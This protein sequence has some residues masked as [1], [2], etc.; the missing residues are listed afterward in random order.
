MMIRIRQTAVAGSF[1][2]AEADELRVEVQRLLDSVHAHAGPAPRAL[3]VPHAGY[4]YSG[5]VAAAAYERL[6]PWRHNYRRVLLMGPC[7]RVAL[8]GMAVSGADYFQTPLGDVPLDRKSI[9]SLSHPDLAVADDAH[10]AEHSLEVQLPFLQ[11]VLDSFTLVPIVVGDAR[12]QA[13]SEV[14]DA[15]WEDPETLV[16]ISS[17]LSHYLDYQ[18]ARSRDRTTCY[19]I[20]ALE[21]S[22][23]GATDACGATPLQGLLIAAGRRGL[24]AVTL[25]LRNSGDT[26]GPQE[27][28]VGYG[29]WMFV[30]EASWNH[31]A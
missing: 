27:R 25:D 10:F 23:I 11:S 22:R 18:T 2:P 14:I 20:E 17:D 4:I 1:Y 24:R 30:E 28:V 16:V 6:R 19:A 7:H 26:A 13:V 9:A 12:P 21:G 31:A 3:V 5:P 29:A 15:L 8:S